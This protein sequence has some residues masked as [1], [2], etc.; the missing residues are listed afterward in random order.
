MGLQNHGMTEKTPK[1]YMF[2]AA[3]LYN[4]LKFGEHYEKCEAGEEGAKK[5]VESTTS[6]E[7]EV[8]LSDVVE[9]ANGYVPKVGDYVISTSGWYGTP[10]AAT[11]DGIKLNIEEEIIVPEIDG[12][13]VEAEGAHI[14]MPGTA[15]ITGNVTEFKE[16]LLVDILHLEADSSK[17]IKGYKAYKSRKTIGESDYKDNFA[18]VGELIDGRKCIVIF[19]KAIIKNAF[20]LE[21][22]N[23][24]QASYSIEVSCVAPKTQT[25]LDHLPY[26]MYFEDESPNVA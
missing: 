20:E 12:V 10:Y 17:N 24:E 22:K 9:V 3:V 16:N 23:K 8:K 25:R 19:P 5:I 4:G 14:K 15:I 18:V 13:L 7:N 26:E 2:A 1:S 11:T 21:M 6:G